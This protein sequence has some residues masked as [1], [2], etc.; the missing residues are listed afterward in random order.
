MKNRGENSQV[1][2]R[3]KKNITGGGESGVKQ[4]YK[5]I[6]FFWEKTTKT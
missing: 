3:E 1:F 5:Q 6:K 2:W 4:K